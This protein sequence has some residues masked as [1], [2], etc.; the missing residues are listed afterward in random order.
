VTDPRSYIVRIK[1]ALAYVEAHLDDEL[2]VGFRS[3]EEMLVVSCVVVS[4][5][6]PSLN[7]GAPAKERSSA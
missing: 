6:A 4:G 2:E 5:R 7:A 1:R 3:P